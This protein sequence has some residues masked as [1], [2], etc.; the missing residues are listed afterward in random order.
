MNLRERNELK[1]RRERHLT[2]IYPSLI[3]PSDL[4]GKMRTRKGKLSIQRGVRESKRE[5]REREE[6]ER[7]K[8]E[9]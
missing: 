9:K 3:S 1:T 4:Y 2:Q 7:R 8:R 6:T 5:K